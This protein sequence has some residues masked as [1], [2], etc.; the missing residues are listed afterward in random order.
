MRG[1]AEINFLFP[2]DDCKVASVPSNKKLIPPSRHYTCNGG[3]R[4]VLLVIIRSGPR[5]QGLYYARRSG[6][7]VRERPAR[8]AWCPA[9]SRYC[10]FRSTRSFP[11][12]SRFDRP[13]RAGSGPGACDGGGYGRRFAWECGQCPPYSLQPCVKWFFEVPT[14][15]GCRIAP[16][17]R[18]WPARRCSSQPAREWPCARRSR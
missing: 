17:P 15:G 2:R 18:D 1:T 14:G 4:R 11:V 12:A 16:A 6:I 3:W 5:C 7:P 13:V 10:H 8:S 9:G